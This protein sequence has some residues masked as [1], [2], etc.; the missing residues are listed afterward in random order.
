MAKSKYHHY[1]LVLSSTGAVFVTAIEPRH[2]AIWCKTE[3]LLEMSK[4]M[5]EN[6]ALGLT[7][8]FTTAFHITVPYELD[9]Q[10]Y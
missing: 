7:M 1:V 9:T 2:T 3:K 10:P 8:N 6:V 5:A 4:D